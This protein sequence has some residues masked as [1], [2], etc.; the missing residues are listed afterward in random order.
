MSQAATIRPAAST[1]VP[2]LGRL[3]VEMVRTHHDFDAERFIAPSPRT[4][5]GYGSFLGSQV[6]KE[7]TILLVADLDGAVV[8][9]AY[10][11]IEGFDYMSLRGPAGILVDIVVDSAHRQQGIGRKL[12][13]AA[14]AAFAAR[15]VSQVVLSTAER[16]AAGQAL[17]AG[18]GFRRTMVEMTRELDARSLTPSR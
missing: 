10:G 6:G 2:A 8:A 1:D 13:D 11:T 14:L 17:F 7:G 12:L 15:G 3:G 18:A 9:Y 4:E 16:N 5:Q